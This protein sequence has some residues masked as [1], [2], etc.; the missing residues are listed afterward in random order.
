MNLIEGR[1]RVSDGGLRFDGPVA[2]RLDGLGPDE[3]AGTGRR[4]ASGRS[5]SRW[6][7]P[8][9]SG[10]VPGD[11]ELVERGRL[12]LVSC[13]LMPSADGVSVMARVAGDTRVHEGE[14][15]PHALPAATGSGC[16]TPRG[17]RVDAA[18]ERQSIS[19]VVVGRNGSPS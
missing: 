17:N 12:R 3:L 6:S 11:V 7:D 19:R 9:T 16:S 5:T 10:A 13:S 18:E 14:R 1:V 2:R 4:S 15:D 8:A